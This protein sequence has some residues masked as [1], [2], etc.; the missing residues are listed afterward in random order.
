MNNVQLLHR[1]HIADIAGVGTT[2]LLVEG[3]PHELQLSQAFNNF[4]GYFVLMVDLL[5]DGRIFFSANSA[6]SFGSGLLLG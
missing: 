6:P 4:L 5:G 3:N 1:L 2:E